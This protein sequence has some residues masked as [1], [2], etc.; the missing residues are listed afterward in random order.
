MTPKSIPPV[1]RDAGASALERLA[2]L[3]WLELRRILRGWRWRGLLVVA[4]AAAIVLSR[5]EMFGYAAAV[6]FPGG[7][8]GATIAPFVLGLGA[9]VLGA[10]GWGGLERARASRLAASRLSQPF[11]FVVSRILAV[12]ASI[13]IIAVFVAAW[14]VLGAWRGGLEVLVAPSVMYLLGVVAPLAACGAAS[15]LF[16]RIAA[17]GDT[18]GIVLG[19][20]ALAPALW[21]RMAVSEPLDV[22]VRVS[23][24]LGTLVPTEVIARDA[25]ITACCALPFAGLAVLLLPPQRPRTA[26]ASGRLDKRAALATVVSLRH[27]CLARI[28]QAGLAAAVPSLLL[29]GAGAPAF[30][31]AAL[32]R[33]FPSAS[34]D[35]TRSAEPTG[36]SG[37]R[38]PAARV[39]RREVRLGRTPAD[40]VTARISVAS[41]APGTSQA[42][43]A[44]TFGPALRVVS[45]TRE[46]GSARVVEAIA[47]ED[48]RILTIA[49]DPPLTGAPTPLTIELEVD[50]RAR[51]RWE[52]G[53]APGF[54]SFAGIESWWGEPVEVNFSAMTAGI[55]TR[56]AP[57]R[58][59]LPDAGG[60]EWVCG[61]SRGRKGADGGFVIESELPGVPASLLAA[62]LQETRHPRAELDLAWLAFPERE[63]L[64]RS[65]PEVYRDA[66][67]RI[68]RLF[69]PQEHRLL[70]Y[71][72]PLQETTDL[73][74][75][76]SA[77]LDRLQFA[78]PRFRDWDS[79]SEQ[80]FDEAFR[81]WNLGLVTSIVERSWDTFEDDELLRGAMIRYLNE[82]ALLRGETRT[83][84]RETRL[85]ATIAPWRFARYRIPRPPAP[86]R[87]RQGGFGGPGGPGGPRP[88]PTFSE[89]YFPFDLRESE[90]R[91]F[92]GPIGPSRPPAMAPVT[93]VRRRAFIHMLRTLVG[94]EAFCATIREVYGSR[95]GGELTMEHLRRVSEKHAGRDLAWFFR[96][97]A[98]QGAVPR[99]RILEVRALLAE[100]PRTRVIEY[101]TTAKIAN[102]GTGTVEVPWL[103]QTEGDPV[104]GAT[105]LGPGAE[106]ELTM[107]TLARPTDFA[108]DPW[109]S[110]ASVTEF[111]PGS[112]QPIHP[113]VFIKAI[114]EM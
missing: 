74:A 71:E 86:P 15:G 28:R 12:F 76:P 105:V 63:R 84:T 100:N 62:R 38:I 9:L 37:G 13:M 114:A 40:R 60:M 73:M 111:D 1:G 103:L 72:V 112:R 79:P 33:P 7:R 106:E 82:Y 25:A 85:D 19:A 31:S 39:L 58:I 11:E 83:L 102:R 32:S 36:T 3:S 108:L 107:V 65:F 80:E 89:E 48:A 24:Q 75:M 2:L 93:E 52:R 5:G 44:M 57:F 68:E 4:G 81:P 87:P 10:E 6:F 59:E 23:L 56:P 18:S 20:A 50:P 30:V 46:G 47:P 101:R 14:P 95:R 26:L 67:G 109:G 22:F 55:V 51:R 113:R 54:R 21:F 97:W 99:L 110:V 61:S 94:D 34:I 49:F 27:R 70:F 78:L 35:W 29:V 16:G 41:A 8:L 66:L 77:V 43:A 42:V 64:L 53:Y 92:E 96:D 17:G 45:I 90:A 69:G 104:E 98:E 88:F 91:A